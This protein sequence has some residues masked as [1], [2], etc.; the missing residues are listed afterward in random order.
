MRD[1]SANH[2]F[3]SV[4]WRYYRE[5]GRHDLPWRQAAA[6]QNPYKIMLSEL[7]LQQTQVD[8]VIPKYELFLREFPTLHALAAADQSQVLSAWSG[9]GYNRRARYIH[10]AAQMIER[11]YKNKFPA[12]H[13]ELVT[14]PGVGPNTAGAILAYAYNQPAVFIETNVRTVFF[15]PLF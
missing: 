11:D 8:R 4:L 3:E 13:D 5:H 7:M 2:N 1:E 12:T 10:Q 14:L 9:L 15:A 6:I